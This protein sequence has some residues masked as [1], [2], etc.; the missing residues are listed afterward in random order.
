MIIIKQPHNDSF[1][2]RLFYK[3]TLDIKKPAN[4]IYMWSIAIDPGH[5]VHYITDN[6]LFHRKEL[7]SSINQDLVVIGI[8]DHLTSGW[9]N[10][11]S[12]TKPNL[13]LYLED[14]FEFYKDKTFILFTSLENL[15]LRNTNVHV[16]SWGGDLTNQRREYQKLEPVLEK[17]L[18]SGTSFI[19]LNRNNRTHRTFILSAIYGMNLE[20]T[21]FIT[22]MY[23]DQLPA[24]I[25]HYS[26]PINPNHLLTFEA[27][28]DKLKAATFSASDSYNIYPEFDNNNAYNF[29]V[30]LRDYYRNSFVEVISETSFTESAY[31]LTEKTLNSIYGCNFPILLS[32]MGAVGFLRNMGLD[33]FD[34]VIDHSYDSIQDPLERI[35]FALERNK[36]L[37]NNVELA[38]ELW[39]KHKKR[40]ENNVVFARKS[41]Y[42]FY[43]NRTMEKWKELRYLYDNISK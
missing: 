39:T 3:L 41:L 14:M 30:S 42:E 13:V 15:T 37:L 8:K 19:N 17:N 35:Y 29:D 16:I 31:L 9:F 10:P 28:F 36:S 27:G 25:T 38:K 5:N 12:E 20:S 24:S 21:G 1:T 7:L 2:K 33:M 4:T 6:E 23:Q 34:D 40:F 32:G 26:L 11:Y 18:N 43:E 22:C